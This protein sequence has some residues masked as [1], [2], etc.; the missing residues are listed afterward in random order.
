MLKLPSKLISINTGQ[1]HKQHCLE[2]LSSFAGEK[3]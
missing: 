2:C 1:A 3:Q